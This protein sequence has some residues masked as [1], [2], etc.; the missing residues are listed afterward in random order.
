[1]TEEQRRQAH[2]KVKSI[3]LTVRG[4][5]DRE[6]SLDDPGG[7]QQKLLDLVHVSGSISHAESVAKAIYKAQV[8]SNMTRIIQ[9]MPEL[10]SA[11]LKQVAEGQAEIYYGQQIYAE[12]LGRMVSHAIEGMRSIVSLHKTELE[13]SNYTPT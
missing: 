7:C 3:L 6:V 4:V 10:G 5:T 12:R 11:N 1:M 13:Q 2:E 8:G 9:E